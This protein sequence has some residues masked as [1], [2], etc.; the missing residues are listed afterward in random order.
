MIRFENVR[1]LEKCITLNITATARM[2]KVIFEE[3]GIIIKASVQL[4]SP[5]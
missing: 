5:S 1:L 2:R 4:K 3:L